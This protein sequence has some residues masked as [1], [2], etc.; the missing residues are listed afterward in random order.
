MTATVFLL[1]PLF[2]AADKTRPINGRVY[3]TDF[4]RATEEEF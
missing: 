2:F 1:F 3:L 4:R